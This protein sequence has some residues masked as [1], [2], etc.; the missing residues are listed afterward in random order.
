MIPLNI[1][2]DKP[3]VTERMT[4]NKKQRRETYE[5]VKDLDPTCPPV[6]AICHR[7]IFAKY[8]ISHIHSL[9]N[10]GTDSLS[11][12]TFTHPPCNLNSGIRNI[13]PANLL[14][15]GVAKYMSS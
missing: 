4:A 7:P 5:Q 15:N 10:G 2:P 14:H 6:C 12:T 11:N 8:H 9:A 1:N 3:D 13:E